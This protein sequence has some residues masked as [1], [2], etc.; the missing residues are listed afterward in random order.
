[1]HALSPRTA[2][3]AIAALLIFAWIAQGLT[4]DNG[5]LR[6]SVDSVP[7]MPA[8][9]PGLGSV[10]AM[11][12]EPG[13]GSV[14]A[15]AAEQADPFD[16]ASFFPASYFLERATV[17]LPLSADAAT[18]LKFDAARMAFLS[19]FR[20]W[21]AKYPGVARPTRLLV[22]A[23]ADI[24]VPL[25]APDFVLPCPYDGGSRC[26][27]HELTL[28]EGNFSLII[29]SQVV[30]HL[31]DPWLALHRV[32][33]HMAPGGLLILSLPT[34]NKPHSGAGHY[35]HFTA[36]GIALALRRTGFE[37]LELGLY[38]CRAWM[39]SV[40]LGDAWPPY[41]I[42]APPQVNGDWPVMTWV[43][44]K[45]IEQPWQEAG[46]AG[47]APA[48][49]A[50]TTASDA[51]PGAAFLCTLPQRPVIS[52]AESQAAYDLINPQHPAAFPSATLDAVQRALPNAGAID[53][54]LAAV[55]AAAV[56]LVDELTQSQRSIARVV[57]DAEHSADFAT[58]IR[59]ALQAGTAASTP[60]AVHFELLQ[61]VRHASAKLM[62][63]TCNGG[64]GSGDGGGKL[65]QSAPLAQASSD[66]TER[67]VE[68]FILGPALH[69]TH[70]V[71]ALLLATVDAARSSS[72]ARGHDAIFF[73]SCR[74]LD[75][76]NGPSDEALW[77]CTPQ[78]LVVYAQ[79]AGLRVMRGSWW[80]TAGY[81]AELVQNKRFQPLATALLTNATR[82]TSSWQTAAIAWVIAR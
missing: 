71:F 37:V 21:I 8:A 36:R 55:M 59:A 57:L 15:I 68:V 70:D 23:I 32:R 72:A 62:S 22:D 24:E 41:P 50:E 79:R 69:F 64:G 49:N 35:A 7:A 10:S 9:E 27:Y 5:L 17:E 14:W 43:L 16:T 82:E 11:P 76:V 39:E 6:R 42:C 47:N 20:Q 2:L 48:S 4:R 34:L 30:E 63:Q 13:L 73:L 61:T 44:A 25:L 65:Q 78:G 29:L 60:A 12:A 46:H 54:A 51:P 67:S 75:V 52:T 3:L 53:A 19:D 1:M 66:S 77:F 56:F 18:W 33:S 40:F 81:A 28:P 31:Y 45:R 58:V 38:G 74:V 26:D 80:G